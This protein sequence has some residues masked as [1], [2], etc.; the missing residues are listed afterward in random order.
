[1]PDLTLLY[2][3][4]DRVDCAITALGS[5]MM[6]LGDDDDGRSEVA[7]IRWLYGV[8]RDEADNTRGCVKLL[9][10]A[11]KAREPA[12]PPTKSTED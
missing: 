6:E 4:I 7:T 3:A 9:D 12:P 1:M 5:V 11:L 8:L 2:G 10:E